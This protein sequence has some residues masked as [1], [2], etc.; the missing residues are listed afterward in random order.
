MILE[1]LH[2]FIQSVFTL[3]LKYLKSVSRET[4]ESTFVVKLSK[5]RSIFFSIIVDLSS[6]SCIPSIISRICFISIFIS[7]GAA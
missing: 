5:A 7:E 3:F 4:K 6:F 1:E 2:H